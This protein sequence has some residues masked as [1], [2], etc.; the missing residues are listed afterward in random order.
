M[1][2]EGDPMGKM[3]TFTSEFIKVVGG[4]NGITSKDGKFSFLGT[5][6]TFFLTFYVRFPQYWGLDGACIVGLFTGAVSHFM[7]GCPS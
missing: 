3:N 7:S 2:Y 5:A 4:P 6:C 1:G